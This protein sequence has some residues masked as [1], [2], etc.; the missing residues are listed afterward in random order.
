MDQS[1][2][3]ALQVGAVHLG[4]GGGQEVAQARGLSVREGDR[5]REGKDR[6][7]CSLQMMGRHVSADGVSQMDS[8]WSS[9][10]SGGS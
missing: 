4:L 10:N 2:S 6:W 1:Q 9:G 5:G 3:R 8:G 7:L